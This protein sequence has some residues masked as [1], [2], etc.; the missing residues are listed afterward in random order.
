[1]NDTSSPIGASIGNRTPG[2]RVPRVRAADLKALREMYRA[3]EARHQANFPGSPRGGFAIG[4]E[5]MQNVCSEGADVNAAWLRYVL[6]QSLTRALGRE[7]T[8][9]ILRLLFAKVPLRWPEVGCPQS[10]RRLFWATPPSGK[11]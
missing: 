5:L 4:T 8:P 6:L 3:A 9:A 7:N 10:L 1:M 2:E 11:C